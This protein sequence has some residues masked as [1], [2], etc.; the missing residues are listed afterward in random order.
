MSSSVDELEPVNPHIAKDDSEN[1]HVNGDVDCIQNNDNSTRNSDSEHQTTKDDQHEIDKVLDNKQTNELKND[2]PDHEIVFTE[3][4][5]MKDELIKVQNEYKK[6]LERERDLCEKLKN[7]Q[8]DEDIKISQLSR[9][10]EDLREQFKDVI[11]E[12]NTKK[13]ELKV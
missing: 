5:R 3:Y 9:V 13:D 7:S 10:N 4:E 11:E 2:R 12:L 1:V 6:S 8:Q